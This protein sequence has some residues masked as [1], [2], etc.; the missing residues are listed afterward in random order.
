MNQERS[1]ALLEVTVCQ[2][3]MIM[4]TE[5]IMFKGERDDLDKNSAAR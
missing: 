4:N 5:I 3:E 1:P 2:G